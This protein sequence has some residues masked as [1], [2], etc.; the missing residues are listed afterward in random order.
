[1]FVGRIRSDR[2][3][4]EFTLEPEAA[5]VAERTCAL[6]KLAQIELAQALHT[7]HASAHHVSEGCGSIGQFVLHRGL[8][9]DQGR[10]LRYVGTAMHTFDWV[11]PGLRVGT[12][13]FDQAEA[14]GQACDVEGAV[15]EGDEWEVWAREWRLRDLRR[16][17][18]KRIEEVRQRK[19]DLVHFSAFLS[20][21]ALSDYKRAR[22]LASRKA[23][24]VLTR[25]QAL[26]FVFRDFN[27][28]HDPEER[29]AGKRRVGDTSDPSCR[30][31]PAETLRACLEHYGDRCWVPGCTNEIFL[32]SM[33][34]KPNREGG[35]Q[36]PQNIGRGCTVHHTLHDAGEIWII[37]YNEQKL[38]IFEMMNGSI[39][40]PDFPGQPLRDSPAS[41]DDPE[42]TEDRPTPPPR[43]SERG[44]RWMGRWVARDDG[45]LTGP[46]TWPPATRR[47][48]R[49]VSRGPPA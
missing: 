23:K 29:E 46:R 18:R 30:T 25:G 48:R 32:Q 45:W 31:V 47:W 36:E 8:S 44:A 16:F 37:G 41:A 4:I 28:R 39:L 27:R 43:V 10:S 34:L 14:V 19:K 2:R 13:G 42:A 24:E 12:I 38:P 21:D 1:M 15:R 9:P 22:V 17:V 5:G 49:Q 26:A 6:I 40:H 11:E 20:R 7:I 35:S 3:T 33:H